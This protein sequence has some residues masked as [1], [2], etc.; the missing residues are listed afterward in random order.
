MGR[1]FLYYHT[2]EHRTVHISWNMDLSLYFKKSLQRSM[3]DKNLTL[4]LPFAEFL[5]RAG[6]SQNGPKLGLSTS[7]HHPIFSWAHHFIIPYFLQSL[8]SPPFA[9]Q[10][11]Q[12]DLLS[13]F[14][15]HRISVWGQGVSAPNLIFWNV[16]FPNIYKTLSSQIFLENALLPNISKRSLPHVW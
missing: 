11:Q 10:L 6:Q 12:W 15:I 7:L 1:N 4:L 5:C 13:H 14:Y 8:V 9:P 3:I 16:L 2:V